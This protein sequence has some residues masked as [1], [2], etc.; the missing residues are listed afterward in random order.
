MARPAAQRATARATE[1]VILGLETSCD[2]TAAALVTED[3][4]DRARTSSPRRPSCTR[5][6][7]GS[8][9]RSRRGAT[10][11]SSSRSLRTALDEAGRGLEDV[12]R[13]AVTRGPGLIG[14]LLV[15]LSAAK[16][17]AWSR[18]LPLVPV[19]HLHG[20]RRLALPRAGPAGA[21]VRLP[22]RERRAHDAARR[23]RARLVRPC[24]ARRSTTRPARHSTRARGCSGSATR[25]APRSTGSRARATPRRIAFPV[26]RVPGLDFSFSGLKTALALRGA[27]AAATSSSARAPTSRR[28]TSGRSCGRS[29]GR[30][31]EAQAQTGSSGS[32]SSAASRRTRSC[33]PRCRT[34]RSRRSRSAPTTPR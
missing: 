13:V 2:E 17:L 12:D 27:R 33:A 28:A 31:R 5:A 29:S 32:R 22:A 24:S 3:G 11:S 8:C 19:D 23:A 10:S 18:R 6:T 7:A 34:L 16:A 9:P 14:A 20:P 4:R 26:A 30:L 21:A 25:A 1:L 15:G